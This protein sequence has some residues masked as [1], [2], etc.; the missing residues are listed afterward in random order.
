F[1]GQVGFFVNALALRADLKGEPTAQ[2]LIGRVREACLDAFSHQELPFDHLVHALRPERDPSRNP[3]FQ[4]M[5]G[6]HNLS[7][8]PWQAGEVTL[9]R[10]TVER[11]S[12]Q[13]DLALDMHESA[14]GVQA[15]FNYATDLFDEATVVRIADHWRQI[16]EAMVASPDTSVWQLPMLSADELA[17][18]TER[19]PPGASTDRHPPL[20]EMFE[21]Q[22]ARAPEAVAVVSSGRTLTY[23]A[24]DQRAN[25]IA[26]ALRR[27]GVGRDV[28][29]GLCVSRSP[30]MVAGLLGV[31]KAG[32]AHVPLDPAY[33]AGRLAQMLDDC[34]PR[35]LVTEETLRA[36]LPPLPA[37]TEVICLDAAALANE[38]TQPPRTQTAPSDLAYAIYTSGSTGQPKAALLTHGGLSN[39]AANE[40]RAFGVGAQ[41]RIL[42]FSSLSFDTS[43]SEIALALCSGAALHV[44]A[45]ERLLPGPDLERYLEREKITVL[46]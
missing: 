11:T 23:R 5:C 30:D 45:R 31:L 20:H 2:E 1:E 37:D 14:E 36:S 39:L 13:F 3:L 6:L 8:G 17:Q 29:V 22:A 35:V 44:E 16:L 33:P 41:S 28:L 27:H 32:G 18:A 15:I 25:Q 40:F 26:H 7:P 4:V 38:S 43:L 46:S 19:S 9:S 42:Q 21:A 10:L 34:R 24:L 12:A